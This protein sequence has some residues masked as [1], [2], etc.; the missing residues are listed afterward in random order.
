MLVHPS[1]TVRPP[2]VPLR[3]T[4]VVVTLIPSEGTL[5]QTGLILILVLLHKV[6]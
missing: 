6:S 4:Q 5:S 3:Q 1:K 2:G